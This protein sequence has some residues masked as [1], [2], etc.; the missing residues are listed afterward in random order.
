MPKLTKRVVEAAK[1]G[2]KDIIIWD[3]ELTGFGLKVTPKGKR[4]YFA[5]YR[6]TDGQ[7][8]RPAIGP[9]GTLTCEE[10]RSIAR[11]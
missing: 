6:T 2:D 9:H 5:Y 4:S 1:P 10:A 7:Q 8:R 3:S 11:G